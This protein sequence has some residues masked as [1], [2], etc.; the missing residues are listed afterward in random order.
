MSG[1]G[2]NYSLD[3][4]VQFLKG[5]GPK[6]AM[7][8]GKLG[9]KTVRDILWF[10]PRRY[11]DRSKLPQLLML[12]AGEAQTVRGRLVDVSTR[13]TRGGKVLIR[14]I[15]DDGTSQVGLV[16][17]NQPWVAR[18]LQKVQGGEIVAFGMVKEGQGR[19][20]EMTSPEWEVLDEDDEVGDFARIT[21][22]YPLTE[23]VPQWAVR[24]AAASAIE[25][26]SRLLE[27]PLT[28]EILRAN[29]LKPL[30]WCI[31]QMH[32]P[33]SPDTLD[34]ARGRLVFEEF[35]YLQLVLQMRRNEVK[36]EVGISFPISQLEHLLPGASPSLFAAA[37]GDHK[38]D[39]WTQVHAMLPFE[40]TGAQKRVIG[41]IWQDMERPY[42]MNR[43]VQ[44]DVGSGKTAV[45]A[46][47]ILAAVKCGYQAA[48]MAPTEILAEQHYL[49]L[50]KLFDPLGIT[51]NLMVGKQTAKQK[52]TAM[53]KAAGGE[54]Q[55]NVGTHALISEG[56][57]F[58]KLGL[59][60]IDEQ[61]RFGVVQ[62]MALRQKGFGHPDVL[63]MT[64][65]PIPR[66]LTMSLYGDL[67]LSV[68]DELPPGRKPIKTH[69]KK[70]WDR[71]KVYATV[72]TLIQEGRQAYFVCP[73]ISES[74]KMQTQAA[75]DLHYRLTH[76]TYPDLRVGL[77]HGQMKPAEKEEVMEQFRRH[78]LDILVSTVVIE[79]GVD[80]PNATVM[81]IEDAN[82]FG[83][84]QLHQLRGRVGRGSHQ[85]FCI[86]VADATNPDSEKR[87][88]ILEETTNGFKIAEED[89]KIRGPGDVVG[90]RQSGEIEF[91]L[92]N[93]V[94]D[95][96]VLETARQAAIGILDRDKNLSRPEHQMLLQKIREQRSY[97]A[98]IVVS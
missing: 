81:V 7:L 32:Q 44:G 88:R 64:A 28:E 29:R 56:V 91:Q 53:E 41:E 47:A 1:A 50:V 23:G 18:E 84:A 17:F 13:G 24:K 86:L 30:S 6:T 8:L 71:D 72:R 39:L 66:T 51:V 14:A 85:S 25:Y 36:Q 73:M 74:D 45:A 54:A 61:H 27:D 97:E 19:S 93:L 60:V 80:V 87:L 58:H 52:R 94:D 89:L 92:A 69:W 31:K 90:T 83:L 82:R 55:V 95:G 10:F 15:L 76:E 77:L 78:D 46:S 11:D 12:R 5:V 43:L 48:M 34:L 49:N 63:V 59:A 70:P 37:D 35:L 3:T 62:R 22:V 98:L 65:T 40:L 38:G 2:A 33:D 4:E 67:D 68:I 57:K 9:I 75:E 79:V 20:L 42:P 26:F 21:P 16:W 96:P